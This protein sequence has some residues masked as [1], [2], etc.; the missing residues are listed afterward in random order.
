V[1]SVLVKEPV[2]AKKTKLKEEEAPATIEWSFRETILDRLDEYFQCMKRL[3]S[4]DYEAYEVFSRLGFAIPA[5]CV[6]A[7][8]PDFL[9]VKR[10]RALRRTLGG[11]LLWATS[12]DKETIYPSFVYF[13]KMRCPMSVE[14]TKGDV[15]RVT[16]VYDD[17]GLYRNVTAPQSCHVVLRDDGTVR[18]L[19]EQVAFF[20]D[21]GVGRDRLRLRT[22]HWAYPLWLY[23][24]A[25]HHKQTPSYMA[26]WFFK[27]AF[28][29]YDAIVE[30]IQIRV[31]KGLM[32][33]MFSIVLPTAKAFFR[34]RKVEVASDGKR[35]R[36]FHSVVEH[37]REYEDGHATT[38]KAHYRGS[39]D[40]GWNNYHVHIVLPEIKQDFTFAGV[41]E[42]DAEVTVNYVGLPQLGE[43]YAKVLSR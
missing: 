31:A 22:T 33:A 30:K 14:A 43:A 27:M 12:E 8:H 9:S 7:E 11:V 18:L 32:V 16:V 42:E 36:I 2:A 10:V 26:E 29:T 34:D 3:K 35:K 1:S 24:L 37:V 41:Y 40:F 38:V 19:R 5:S 4:H 23:D 21:V 6:N 20:S 17:R 13:T 28:F 15:Y 39:R 25:L